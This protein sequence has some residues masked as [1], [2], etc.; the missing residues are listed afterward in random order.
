M[1]DDSY[2][3]SVS[4]INGYHKGKSDG[5][6]EGRKEAYKEISRFI[7]DAHQTLCELETLSVCKKQAD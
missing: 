5:I 2:D 1:I 6:T 7:A 3:K 4:Y